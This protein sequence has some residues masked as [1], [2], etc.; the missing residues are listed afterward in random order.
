MKRLV[1]LLPVLIAL[2]VGVQPALAWTWPVD[3]PVVR[4]F[5]LGDDPYAAGQHRGIDIAAAAGSAVRAPA[6]GTVS[7]AGAVPGGGRTITIRND[8]GYSITLLHL[9]AIAVAR[10]AAIIEGDVVGGVGPSGDA[11]HDEPYVHLGVRLTSD[12]TGYL[13]PLGFLPTRPL[14]QEGEEGPAVPEPVPA[15]QP[16]TEQ[17]VSGDLP[18][19][20]P[21][22]PTRTAGHASSQAPEAAGRS[23]G[24]GAQVRVPRVSKS[25]ARTPL[26]FLETE[27][28]D[29]RS[30]R[31][32]RA[33]T[34]AV[35]T[36]SRPFGVLPGPQAVTR[37]PA[38]TE[39]A[40]HEA[41][42][43]GAALAARRT[44]LLAVV[45]AL[46]GLAGL[47]VLRRK[48]RDA[49]A[50]DRPSAMLL[51]VAGPPAEDAGAPGLAEEDRLVL[52]RDL[53]WVLLG[54][55]EAFSDLARN[56]DP[57]ELVDVANDSRRR[58]SPCPCRRAHRIHT[59][60]SGRS[61]AGLARSPVTS[62]RHVSRF[63]TPSI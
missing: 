31:R 36:E 50:A 60:A 34:R 27:A 43:A 20:S 13:D 12:P 26:G 17:P 11:E 4:P 9:G 2:Q 48:L 33:A 6:G 18:A 46:A 16:G 5:V 40:S 38:A 63:P 7:F 55:A 15:P 42:L 19:E 10:G 54:E 49:G 22:E 28:A 29:P 3:G 8:G 62:G 53:E 21:E 35:D 25:P 61:R 32:N 51:D 41:P 30:P 24:A 52:D 57:A 56:D 58:Y 45:L 23:E 44:G 37:R 59:P 47:A 39:T 1:A 14:A